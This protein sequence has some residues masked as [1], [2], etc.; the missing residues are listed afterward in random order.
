[1]TRAML[2]SPAAA[3]LFVLSGALR[4]Q[5]AEIRGA[6]IALAPRTTA[7]SRITLEN[8][9]DS[10]LLAWQIKTPHVVASADFTW[11]AVTLGPD[12]GP[13]G[14]DERRVIDVPV[15]DDGAVDAAM[16]QLAVF[17]DGRIEG[18]SAAI[19]Q[20]RNDRRDHAADAAYWVRAFEAMPIDSEAR[21]KEF[22]AGRVA[23]GRA[24]PARPLGHPRQAL[25]ALA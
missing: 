20:W 19:E 6:S 12:H 9:R 13:I 5:D 17:A 3:L 18:A 7:V 2:A 23:A 16:L 15:P 25:P 10:A 22:L 1:M 14:P 21:A 4:G 24:V 11:Q 8:H